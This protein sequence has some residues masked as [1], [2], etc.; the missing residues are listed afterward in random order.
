MNFEE[1][2]TVEARGQAGQVPLHTVQ[3]L[4]HLLAVN[5]SLKGQPL[6]IFNL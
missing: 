6:E 3:N 4:A 5:T 1:A 2:A